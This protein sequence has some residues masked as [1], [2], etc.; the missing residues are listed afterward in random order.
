MNLY[1][2]ELGRKRN[3]CHE[4]LIAVFGKQNLVDKNINTS[5]FNLKQEITQETQ[6]M[7]GG[8]I[9]IMEILEQTALNQQDL[10]S[11][12]KKLIE[13]NFKNHEGKVP[14]SIST[15]NFKNLKSINIKELLNFSK[16]ILKS[17]KLNGRFLNKG[18]SPLPPSTIY[19]ARIIEKG[20]D[21]CIIKKSENEVHIG[22]SITIQNIDAYSLR[23][24]QKPKRDAKVGMLPPKLAQIM[25]NLAGESNKIYDPFCGTGT[26]LIE[27][28]LMRKEVVGSDINTRMVEYSKHNVE[29]LCQRFNTHKKYTIFEQ[30]A[31]LINKESAKSVDAIITEGYLGP[32]ISKPPSKDE[33]QKTFKELSTLHLNWLKQAHKSTSK[34]CKIVMCKTAYKIKDQI[35][36][37]PKFEEI[38]E[39]AGYKITKTF[40]YDRA[41]QI[42]VRDIAILE[43]I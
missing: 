39:M 11:S 32:A 34:H 24:Y 2:F 42:V 38:A 3:L 22:K 40:T 41:D 14:F 16:K 1:A 18:S 27:G 9:K 15:L 10:S 20:I 6:D 21:I 29:W 30:D 13:N 36:H 25:I 12:I 33:Q 7:L 19:K 28:L 43:K 35:I 8:T 17:L 4:E 23:D 31:Q 5:I 26:V 37:L